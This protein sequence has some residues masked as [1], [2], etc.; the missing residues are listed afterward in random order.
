MQRI[1]TKTGRDRL[2]TR[3]D[4]HWHKLSSE[5]HLGFRKQDQDRGSWIARYRGD[6]GRRKFKALGENT[7]TFGFDEASTAALKWFRELDRGVV[8]DAETVAD[9]CR[10]YVEDRRATKGDAAAN[11]AHRR[12]E[13]TIYGG[14]GADGKRHEAD[15]LGSV[16]IAMIRTRHIEVWRDALSASGLSRASVNR[17]MINLKAALNYAV[18]RRLVSLDVAIEWRSAAAL[19][20]AY[21]RRNLYLDLKQRRALIGAA[22]GAL[23]DLLQ[24][25][26]LTGARAGELVSVRVG[27]FE[28]RSASITF[29]GKTGART[30][31]L[32]ATAAALF[33]R[34]SKNKLPAAWLLTRDDG[35]P[36]AHS[37]W[38][39][40]VRAAASAA[41]LPNKTCLYTLRHSF[42]TQAI[43]DGMSPLEVARLCGTSLRMIDKNYGHLA[44]DSARERLSQVTMI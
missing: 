6:D 12:F 41:K 10:L 14:G 2:K 20:D 8:S 7:A 30:I 29:A 38:D 18:R 11:D 40:L 17:T 3:R 34:L 15:S 39:E 24:A 33:E 44:A 27:A 26:M 19:S 13:R 21:R 31:P 16:A 4:P 22:S 42:I 23:V 28:K 5:R 35:K 37:D 25:A 36:W 1:D 9:I 43:Q 32:S